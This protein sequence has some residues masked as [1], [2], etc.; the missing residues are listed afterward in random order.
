MALMGLMAISSAAGTL[1]AWGYKRFD[2]GGAGSFAT[3]IVGGA[4]L[5]TTQVL[6]SFGI[7]RKCGTGDVGF[8]LGD[9]AA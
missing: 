1:G 5:R 9:E 3:A 4:A 2:V 6:L 7:N 8:G